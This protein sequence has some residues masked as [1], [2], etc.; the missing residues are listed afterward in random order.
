M[1]SI[2][3]S[4]TPKTTYVSFR[5]IGP[6]LYATLPATDKN[7]LVHIAKRADNG[8]GE[9]YP[10]V[11]SLVEDTGFAKSTVIR[12]IAR[13]VKSGIVLVLSRGN[14]FQKRANN[15]RIDVEKLSGYTAATYS[16]EVTTT[17][18][19][20]KASVTMITSKCHRDR[21]GRTPSAH[22]TSWRTT[23]VR[24]KSRGSCGSSITAI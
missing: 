13:L 18:L 21:I 15:Y 1:H 17:P 11:K 23:G 10:S 14:Q 3:E 7:V 24:S 5:Y 9:C 12:A 6:A 2:P 20:D 16:A 8:T 22:L 4:P 19:R